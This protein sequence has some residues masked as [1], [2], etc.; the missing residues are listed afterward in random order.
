MFAIWPNY[1]TNFLVYKRIISIFSFVSKNLYHPALL[2]LM[3]KLFFL[4]IIAQTSYSI[5]LHFIL[6]RHNNSTII[7]MCKY[8]KI[9]DKFI[10]LHHFMLLRGHKNCVVYNN[11][12]HTHIREKTREIER[13]RE[14][15]GY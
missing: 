7:Y 8:N 4:Q 9:K 6:F 13:K 14:R 15:K 1:I 3:R 2:P 12:T 5:L 11:T 10:F